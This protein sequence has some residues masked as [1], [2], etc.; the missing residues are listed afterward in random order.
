MSY[1]IS[2]PTRVEP[3][4]S[5]ETMAK[6]EQSKREQSTAERQHKNHNHHLHP[7]ADN[8]A[9]KKEGARIIESARGVYLYDSE[10]NKIL[11]GMA[12]LWCV[13]IGYGQQELVAAACNQ[14]K[15]LPY[16][17]TFF[18]TTHNPAIQ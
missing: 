12:G 15:E 6:P 10:H 3:V 8:G 5:A 14:M 7:F 13:N 9:L 2:E 1:T 17:N 16:Y 11:D 18:K 4:K